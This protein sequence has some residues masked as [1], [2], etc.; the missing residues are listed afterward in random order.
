MICWHWPIPSF[1]N[2]AGRD[3]T[4]RFRR[5]SKVSM[6]IFR[7]PPMMISVLTL[8][9]TALSGSLAEPNPFLDPALRLPTVSLDD[10]FHRPTRH[11][12]ARVRTTVQLDREITD[13][14]AFSTRFTPEAYRCFRVWSDDQRLW[15]A[16]AFHSPVGRVFVSKGS[17]AERGLLKAD[18]FQRFILH[19]DVRQVLIGQPW[20]EVKHAFRSWE[21][22][23]E[24]T[25]L[26]ATRG[27]DLLERGAV[28]MARKEFERALTPR[29][30]EAIRLQL[31]AWIETQA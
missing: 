14:N 11:L 19:A 9:L 5:R 18:R 4:D 31:Q 16:D 21:T 1:A 8:L 26:H 28:E 27:L 24:G 22:V 25:L 17:D 30:P 13:W 20:L 10:A 15:D 2:P 23:G 29:L 6:K 3:S 7:G 12:G